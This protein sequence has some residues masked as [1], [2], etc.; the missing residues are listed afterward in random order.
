MKEQL[1]LTNPP[2][3][4][5]FCLH[6]FASNPSQVAKGE[7]QD[8]ATRQC[9]PRSKPGSSGGWVSR[10][11]VTTSLG[12]VL[13]ASLTKRTRKLPGEGEAGRCQAIKK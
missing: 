1:L 3:S 4:P 11:A 2:N 12:N 6:H 10:R 13:E 7:P 5:C 8:K 9:R